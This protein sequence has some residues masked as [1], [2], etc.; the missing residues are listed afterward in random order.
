MTSTSTT[1]TRRHAGAL[2][3]AVFSFSAI[4]FVLWATRLVP[5]LRLAKGFGHFL[6]LQHRQQQL[7][8]QEVPATR[9]FLLLLR[10]S[11]VEMPRQAPSF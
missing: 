10:Q 4:V 5:P 8:Q 9:L 3:T 1:L 11:P 7:E 2:Q 6:G